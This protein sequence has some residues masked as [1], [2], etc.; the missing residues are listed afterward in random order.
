MNNDRNKHQCDFETKLDLYALYKAFGGRCMVSGISI[1]YDQDL[2]IG[3]DRTLDTN[4][5][6]VTGTIMMLWFI[7]RGKNC[8][9]TSSVGNNIFETKESFL[10]LMNIHK[11]STE[12]GFDFDKNTHIYVNI[13]KYLRL[14][15][16]TKR[17]KGRVLITSKS[18]HMQLI[19]LDDFG[20][21]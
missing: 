5:F 13:V 3:F 10:A 6:C 19:D 16:I 21:E 20:V 12:I 2:D 18:E 1:T 14:H 15:F 17:K 9:G 8:N 4:N 7:N 11:S